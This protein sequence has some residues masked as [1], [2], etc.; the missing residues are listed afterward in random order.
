MAINRIEVAIDADDAE[1]E[2]LQALAMIVEAFGLDPMS[3]V[4]VIL[5]DDESGRPI[6]VAVL[7]VEGNQSE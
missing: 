2:G 4:E 7:Q 1:G 5:T 6:I 3:D